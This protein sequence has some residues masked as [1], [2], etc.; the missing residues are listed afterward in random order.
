MIITYLFASV[1]GALTTLLALSPYG[2]LI[3]L[4]RASGRKR[5]RSYRIGLCPLDGESA[6]A[7]GNLRLTGSLIQT[8]VHWPMVPTRASTGEASMKLTRSMRRCLIL[9]D[10]SGEAVRVWSGKRGHEWSWRINNTPMT[11]PVDRCLRAGLL[12]IPSRDRVV[13]SPLGQ[14]VL[15]EV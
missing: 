10:R 7:R 1:I 3:A 12:D 8:D 6:T 11:Q 15:R 4:A 5:R 9:L 13:L 2:W 14:R